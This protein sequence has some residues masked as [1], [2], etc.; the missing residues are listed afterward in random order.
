MFKK[1]AVL[2][3][4]LCC[5]VVV[6]NAQD[7][8]F[9]EEREIYTAL[10]YGDEV[11]EPELWLASATESEVATTATWSSP[12]LGAVSYLDYR[13]YD[14][15]TTTEEI[16]ALFDNTW[17]EAV[18]ANYATWQKTAV[19]YDG[20]V[21]LHEF[22]LTNGDILYNMRYWVEPVEDFTR[23]RAHFIVFPN[24]YLPELD[25][26]SERLFPDLPACE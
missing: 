14:E 2:L 8:L 23:V 7:D 20:D 26:Y 15:G 21:T 24:S 16:D 6:I 17:F 12:S 13:H 22:D 11:F 10:S 9:L 3:M 1:L 4:V 18:F 25:E 19:C 5:G